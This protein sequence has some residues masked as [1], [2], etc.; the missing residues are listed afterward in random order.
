[1]SPHSK[2]TTTDHLNIMKEF[3]YNPDV[4]KLIYSVLF[5]HKVPPSGSKSKKRHMKKSKS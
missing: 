5:P 3:L 1:M 2:F 4:L